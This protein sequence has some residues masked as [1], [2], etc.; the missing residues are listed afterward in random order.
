GRGRRRGRGRGRGG[1]GLMN[2]GHVVTLRTL[3]DPQ[4]PLKKRIRRTKEEIAADRRRDGSPSPRPTRQSARILSKVQPTAQ[5]SEAHTD[6]T[7]IDPPDGQE[8][9]VALEGVSG[10]VAMLQSFRSKAASAS[11]IH[12]FVKSHSFRSGDTTPSSRRNSLRDNPAS[13]YKTELGSSDHGA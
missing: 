3:Q 11:P 4:T 8:S 1:G 6:G 2:G 5:Y 10:T 12:S 9:Q 7:E 13:A